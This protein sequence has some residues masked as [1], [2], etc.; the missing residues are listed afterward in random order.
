MEEEKARQMIMW[1]NKRIEKTTK[2]KEQ[3]TDL[4]LKIAKGGKLC[5]YKEMLNFIQMHQ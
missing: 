4:N 2:Q 5:V 3:A 1:L